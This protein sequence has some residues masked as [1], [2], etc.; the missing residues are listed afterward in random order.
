MASGLKAYGTQEAMKL[1][2][3]L[4]GKWGLY[5]NIPDSDWWGDLTGSEF[6]EQLRMAIPFL[7]E[8]NGTLG[9]FGT[10]FGV[11][12]EDMFFLFDT[13]EEMERH[14]EMIVGDD[15]PTS[16]NPYDGKVR[17]YALTCDNRGHCR[18]ENT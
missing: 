6:V 10:A 11:V 13:Q 9:D 2:C 14:Y 4:T 1:L 15:G 16:L 3:R 17:V 12:G 7:F 5:V 8:D 18:N